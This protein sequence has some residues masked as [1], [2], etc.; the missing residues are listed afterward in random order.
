MAQAYNILNFNTGI[1]LRKV[2][3]WFADQLNLDNASKYDDNYVTA[4]GN[5]FADNYFIESQNDS[6]DEA[7]LRKAIA[8][9]KIFYSD[10]EPQQQAAQ[11][12]TNQTAQAQNQTAAVNA[13]QAKQHQ[14]QTSQQS[15]RV[16]Q[17]TQASPTQT[18]QAAQARTTQQA[19][20]NA[21]AQQGQSSWNTQEKKISEWGEYK[22][23]SPLEQTVRQQVQYN[24]PEFAS[25]DALL[26]MFT[27]KLTTTAVMKAQQNYYQA[28]CLEDIMLVP[29]E[30][31]FY[32]LDSQPISMGVPPNAYVD[33]R[34]E[35][36]NFYGTIN[37]PA[38]LVTKAGSVD[39]VLTRPDID[40]LII[41]LNNNIHIQ[42]GNQ[43]FR[44]QKNERFC[45]YQPGQGNGVL[46]IHSEG[47]S[48]YVRVVRK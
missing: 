12:V 41:T 46:Y 10:E 30:S 44:G 4:L 20:Q 34:S 19:T 43:V 39:L 28:L 31:Q 17:N 47:R 25:I 38:S 11:T 23:E 29:A 37:G 16:A 22:Q 13:T 2:R 27:A 36:A 33:L 3:E 40:V 21:A 32:F 48:S 42:G 6:P 26:Q 7:K 24:F 45:L 8:A 15:G 14:A 1:S 5:H 18:R 35:K 9:F